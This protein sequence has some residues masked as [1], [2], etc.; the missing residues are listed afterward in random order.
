MQLKKMILFV[1]LSGMKV[2]EVHVRRIGM[3][4]LANEKA[5]AQKH[6]K[7]Q[8]VELKMGKHD[9]FFKKS[10]EVLYTVN[11]FL[12]G[13]WFLIGSVC[14]YF[15]AAKTW[16]VSLFVLGSLQ[17]L[18]RPTIRLAHRIHLKNIYRREYE[19]KQ[20]KSFSSH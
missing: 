5:D 16:G 8:Y 11:D 18:I 4:N 19:K 20:K 1:D 14:F 12:L 7:D 13:L 17:M 10:Y 9:L 3:S 6:S 2:I 15:E